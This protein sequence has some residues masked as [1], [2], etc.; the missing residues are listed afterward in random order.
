MIN[1]VEYLYYEKKV[2]PSDAFEAC[3]HEKSQ[4]AK[5]DNKILNAFIKHWKKSLCKHRA[6]LFMNETTD[7]KQLLILTIFEGGFKIFKTFSQQKK[8]IL[9]CTRTAVEITS[10]NPTEEPNKKPIPAQNTFNEGLYLGIT[11]FGFIL[12]ISIGLCYSITP[13]RVSIFCKNIQ[14]L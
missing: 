11:V 8:Y 9:L 7:S 6:M 10:H 4:V 14:N 5:F 3:K 2:L 12:V 13:V 1:K